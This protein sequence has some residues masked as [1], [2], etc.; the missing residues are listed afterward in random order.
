MSTKI[1]TAFRVQ[2]EDL[3]PAIELLRKRAWKQIVKVAKEC[4]VQAGDEDKIFKFCE[5]YS[6]FGFNVII[7]QDDQKAYIL[8]FG[9]ERFT[10]ISS[11]LPLWI[12]EFS[13]WNNSDT[14]PNN[15]TAHEWS[16]RAKTWRSVLKKWDLR[17][18]HFVLDKGSVGRFHLTKHLEGR[19]K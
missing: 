15:M 14:L 10:D 17:L 4:G 2:I 1:Y 16:Y 5:E 13:Y 11:R 18:T 8:V 9:S 7:D 3:H 19:G 6:D 12:E